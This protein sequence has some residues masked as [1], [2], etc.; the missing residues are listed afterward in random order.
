M[1]ENTTSTDSSNEEVISSSSTFSITSNDF[2]PKIYN[3]GS[4]PDKP[5]YGNGI[6]SNRKFLVT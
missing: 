3:H 2:T 6:L 1:S 4:I 5:V